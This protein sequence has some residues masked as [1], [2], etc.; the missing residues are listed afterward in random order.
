MVNAVSLPRGFLGFPGNPGRLLIF[1]LFEEDV[2][3]F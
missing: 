1:S 3:P 2:E